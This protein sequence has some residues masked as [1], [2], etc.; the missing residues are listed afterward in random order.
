MSKI[1]NWNRCGFV[2]ASML[3]AA[4]A[5]VGC[6][7][8]AS[9]TNAT[10][11]QDGYPTDVDEVS[12][13]VITTLAPEP[14]PVTGT[15]DKVHVSYELQVL[16]ASPRLATIT[17]VQTLE[18]GPEGKVIASISGEQIAARSMQIGTYS[19]GTAARNEIPNGR[20]AL[21]LVDDVYDAKAD[22]D[23]KLTGAGG[24]RPAPGRR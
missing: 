18:G 24:D 10:G 20:A 11:I 17:S 3:A 9:G 19:P 5:L 8:T 4:S 6:G 21:I 23:D 16:N 1:R 2:T 14:I 15:D 12:P 13:L 7:S 22:V